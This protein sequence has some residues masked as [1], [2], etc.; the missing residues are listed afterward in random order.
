MTERTELIEATQEALEY[1]VTG[2]V[3]LEVG[4]KRIALVD[5]PRLTPIFT[6]VQAEVTRTALHFR[7]LALSRLCRVVTET[8]T[9][10]IDGVEFEIPV[11]SR[12]ATVEEI[13]E[14]GAF[15]KEKQQAEAI[16]YNAARAC[17][18]R[19]TRYYGLRSRYA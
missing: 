14:I 1:H 5:D 4:P 13:T 6:Y 18:R 16:A 7:D 15:P 10:V 11:T 3:D 9:E 8:R 19:L 12:Q 17:A 2:K